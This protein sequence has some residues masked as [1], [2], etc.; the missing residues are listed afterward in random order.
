MS[1]HEIHSDEEGLFTSDMLKTYESDLSENT[2]NLPDLNKFNYNEKENDSKTPDF[3]L[4]TK[5]NALETKSNLSN[6]EIENEFLVKD[7]INA[8]NVLLNKSL[9][10]ENTESILDLTKEMDRFSLV[11]SNFDFFF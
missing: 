2:L 8:V 3:P 11:V 5:F 6:D 7:K 1:I 10:M 4:F 9:N